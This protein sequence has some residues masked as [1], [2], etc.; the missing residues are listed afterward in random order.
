MSSISHSPVEE[1][2]T[3]ISGATA[4]LTPPLSKLLPGRGLSARISASISTRSSSSTP[5]IFRSELNSLGQEIEMR[6]QRLHRRIET[7]FLL[8]LNGKAFRQ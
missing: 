2:R 5:Q 7:V 8:Q 4:S 1:V 3:T 6:N